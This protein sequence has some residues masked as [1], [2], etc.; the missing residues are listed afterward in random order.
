MIGTLAT[1]DAPVLA[2]IEGSTI[3]YTEGDL[4]TQVSNTITVTDAEGDDIASATVEVSAGFEAGA[5]VLSFTPLTGVT[6]SQTGNTLTFT[7]SKTLAEYQTLLRSVTYQ[8]TNV[9]N[10]S[11][12]TRT[13]RYRVNDGGNSNYQTRNINITPVVNA[14]ATLPVTESFETD[15]EGTRY[16][17][18]IHI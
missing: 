17:S 15:G 14:P 7:G 8:N 11:V 5:D 18:L 12:A 6:G 1:N 2:S 13:I 10:P 9:I 3:I 4:S 16:L